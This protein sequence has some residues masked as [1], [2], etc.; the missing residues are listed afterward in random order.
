MA[1]TADAP[2]RWRGRGYGG[3]SLVLLPR[4][5]LAGTTDAASAALAIAEQVG[6]FELSALGYHMSGLAEADRGGWD[7][8]EPL[9][10]EARSRW[11]SVGTPTNEAMAIHALSGI[12]F[13]RGDA[14]TSVQL[15]HEALAIFRATGHASGAALSHDRLGQIAREWGDHHNAV[16]LFQEAIRLWASIGERWLCVRALSGLALVASLYGQSDRA[17]MLLGFAG[18]RLQ[19]SGGSI[20]RAPFDQAIQTVRSV[21]GE[22]QFAHLRTVG[23]TLTMAEIVAVAAAVSAPEPTAEATG[24]AD[25][26]G[27]PSLT[28]RE[29]EVLRLLAAGQTDREIAGALF[30]SRRTANTH[31]ANILGKLGVTTRRDAASQARKLGVLPQDDAPP[32]HT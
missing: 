4:G 32:R 24:A 8:A 6:D 16:P 3:L 25:R 19:E 21:L 15:A 2:T 14:E 1:H 22:E 30:I 17:A 18:A 20:A 31:V 29:V 12:V 7:R 23:E 10:M 27:E 5:D 26:L 13:R 28:P 11:R 9:M